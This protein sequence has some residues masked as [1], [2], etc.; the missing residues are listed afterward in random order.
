MNSTRQ[1]LDFRPVN[2]R[3]EYREMIHYRCDICKCEL[4][5]QHDT[6]YVVRMEVYPAP[7]DSPSAI[8]DDRDHLEDIQEVL[9]RF[10]EFDADGQLPVADTYQTRRFD[11]C[12]D[13]CKRFLKQ[14][15][16]RTVATQFNFS[17]R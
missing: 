8:D 12:G 10:Q 7:A 5:P 17:K 4:D 6:S 1:A 2:L 3:K 13:C 9:E 11:L 16:P 15:L 14:P